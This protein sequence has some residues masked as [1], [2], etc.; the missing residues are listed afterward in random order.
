ML[1]ELFREVLLLVGYVGNGNTFP[2]PLTSEQERYWLQ[3][4][5]SGTDQE[6]AEARNTL[7]TCNLRLVAHIAK[8]YIRSG[9]DS[10]DVISIGTI[11]L[12]KA[13][14][15]FNAE[16]G[17]AL[18]SY[19]AR[20]IENEI[21]MSIRLER[22]QVSEVSISEP[23]GEDTDGNSLSISEL[24]GTDPDMI[25]DIVRQRIDS[26]RIYQ[27]MRRTLSAR[28]FTVVRLRYGLFGAERLSQ[29]E[30]SNLLG[31]SRSYVS[32]I[33]KKALSK[34]YNA[35]NTNQSL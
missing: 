5:H 13:V 6:R 16:K 32:R 31:I 7:I 17:S 18:S 19:A 26:E 10:D 24:L 34:L 20:C 23:I 29:R 14:S 21:L 22:R 33:E 2:E 4:L 35:L 15:T 12:I 3:L 25:F 8:K 9:R 30:I 28:E 11:G 27:A 1:F